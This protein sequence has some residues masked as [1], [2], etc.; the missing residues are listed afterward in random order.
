MHHRKICLQILL[1]SIHAL[2]ENYESAHWLSKGESSY[3]DHLL[4]ER[5]YGNVQEE[6]DS[7]AERLIGLHGNE[8]YTPGPHMRRVS[9]FISKWDRIDCL[10]RRSIY[11]EKTVLNLLESSYDKISHMDQMTLGLDD[12]IMSISS[13]HETHMYLLKQKLA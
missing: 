7:L 10:F 1:S 3:G 4:F 12:L 6:V 8:A 2:E 9:K 13:Q 11:A 5:L